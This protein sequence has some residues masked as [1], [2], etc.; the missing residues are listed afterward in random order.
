M[1]RA[2]TYG[3]RS[4]RGTEVAALYYSLVETAKLCNV[5]PSDYLYTAAIFAIEF[6]EALLPWEYA[7][8]PDQA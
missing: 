6:G 8:L 2:D 3:S 1:H 5:N 4:K 7:A